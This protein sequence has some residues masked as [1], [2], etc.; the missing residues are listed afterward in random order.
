MLVVSYDIGVECYD[1]HH[2]ISKGIHIF[3][4]LNIASSLDVLEKR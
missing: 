2:T 1:A 4:P 3:M